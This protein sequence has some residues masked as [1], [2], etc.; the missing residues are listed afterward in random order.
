[1]SFCS[2]TTVV[3]SDHYK[4]SDERGVFGDLVELQMITGRPLFLLAP[5]VMS[6]CTLL[7]YFPWVTSVLHN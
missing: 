5:L 3:G 6:F 4:C 2:G 1:M 7:I